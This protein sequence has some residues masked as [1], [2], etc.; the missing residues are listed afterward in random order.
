MNE[1]FASVITGLGW[2]TLALVMAALFA[3]VALKLI[4]WL[5]ERAGGGEPEETGGAIT[6]AMRNLAYVLTGIERDRGN[7]QALIHDAMFYT[8]ALVELIQ[9]IALKAEDMAAESQQ[10]Q[11]ALE[12][13][14]AQDPLQIARAAGLVKDQHIRTL[15]L[16]RVRSSDYWLDTSMLISTQLG[17]LQQ[18]ERGYRV[19][20]GNLLKEVSKSKARLAASSAAVELMGASK[21]LLQ[22]QANLNKAQACL[23][24]QRQ[25]GIQEAARSLP[26]INAGLLGGE[27]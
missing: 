17:T 11:G 22:T 2:I 27:R 24:L 6:D 18:W 10:L 21:P 16:S 3:L 25:P 20:A 26:A 14:A 4:A 7:A 12:A 1:N 19:F 13:I 5:R 23:Q 15:L 8:Q 9:G